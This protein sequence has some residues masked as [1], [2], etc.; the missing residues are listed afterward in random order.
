MMI[1]AEEKLKQLRQQPVIIDFES[2]MA[3]SIAGQILNNKECKRNYA[4][5]LAIAALRISDVLRNEDDN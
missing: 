1:S 3:N 4:R 2:N 5:I